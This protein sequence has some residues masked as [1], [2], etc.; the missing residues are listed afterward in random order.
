MAA[1][2]HAV[3]DSEDS[4]LERFSQVAPR[5]DYL[6]QTRR[7]LER[8]YSLWYSGVRNINRSRTTRQVQLL[9][10]VPFLRAIIE[11]NCRGYAVI[12]AVMRS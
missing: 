12:V 1:S 2:L 11:R 8:W 3:D 10:G 7:N 4:G 6:C 5:G 9:L